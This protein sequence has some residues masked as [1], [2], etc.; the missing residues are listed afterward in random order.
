MNG[1][2]PEW[3]LLWN[4]REVRWFRSLRLER[5][6]KFVPSFRLGVKRIFYLQPS[7]DCG[8][9]SGSALRHYAFKIA[10][11]HFVEQ[12]HAAA[13]DVF[14]SDH[15]RQPALIDQSAQ[16]FLAL[17]QGEL[18][19]VVIIQVEQIK[20]VKGWAPTAEK[21]FVEDAPAFRIQ[22][23]QFAVDHR[24]L[25]L[26]LREIVAEVLKTFVRVPLARDQFA[27]AIPDV[28]ECAEAVVFQFKEEVWV[29]EGSSDEA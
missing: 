25:H 8:V 26:Q 19:Q 15:I 12:I 10:P 16:L 11:H 5:I 13:F 2:S 9:R 27:I 22:A 1:N 24:V 18:S 14:S 29:V 17:Y 28:R 6:E 7:A 23:H 21:K 4:R 20:R 3:W